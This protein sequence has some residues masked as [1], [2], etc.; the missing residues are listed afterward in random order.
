MRAQVND[1]EGDVRHPSFTGN[2]EAK[3]MAESNTEVLLRE[4]KFFENLLNGH[5]EEL[6][7]LSRLVELPAHTKMFEQYEE[8]KDVYII[9]SGQVSLVI[10]EPKET[11]RQI[12]VLGEGDLVG[13]SPI[14]GRRRLS[15]TAVTLTATRALVFDGADLMKFASKHPEFGFEFMRVVASTLAERLGA[16]Q[17]QLLEMCGIHFPTFEFQP[18]SD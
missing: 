16:S 10:C 7:K 17:L 13:W 2:K 1:L 8:A 5:A 12:A 18:E 6:A 3:I 15:D 9:L 11:C 14:V 4:S